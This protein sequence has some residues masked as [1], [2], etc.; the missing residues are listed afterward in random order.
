M[1]VARLAISL[2]EELERQVRRAAGKQPLST[3]MADAA[4]KKLRSEGLLRIVGEWEAE[5]GELDAGE[6]EEA[7]RRLRKR[8][9]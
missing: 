5:H 1:T 4:R 2:D 6:L 3:W 9:R 8:R 7:A